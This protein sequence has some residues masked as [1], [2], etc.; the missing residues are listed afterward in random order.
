MKLAVFTK[1][2]CWQQKWHA[3]YHST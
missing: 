1:A 2:V 3:K